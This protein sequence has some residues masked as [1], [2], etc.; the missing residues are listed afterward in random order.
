[1]RIAILIL[2][3][4]LAGCL[5]PS[6]LPPAHAIQFVADQTIRTDGRVYRSSLYHRDDMWRIEHNDSGSIEITIVRKDK[7][8]IWHLLGRTRQFATMPFDESTDVMLERTMINE[9]GRELIGTEVLE[10]HPTS[11]YQVTVQDGEQVDIYYQ[12]WAD[13]LQLP[14]R[15]ARR[16]GA[17]TVQYKNVRLRSLSPRLFELPLNYR[18]VESETAPAG[19]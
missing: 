16:D 11:V 5:L 6:V 8:L 15:L 12:W 1:M 14:L 17:W 4:V 13:D 19:D 18:P 3:L 2:T 7:G 10:G 9:A